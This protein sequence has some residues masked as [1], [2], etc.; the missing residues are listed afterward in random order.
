M[1]D[2]P[3]TLTQSLV[4]KGT[5]ELIYLN[6]KSPILIHCVIIS[7][8]G[9]RALNEGGI[10]SIPQLAFPGGVLVGCSPGFMNV[11]KIKGTHNAM[12]SA[13]VAADSVYDTVMN[14]SENSQTAGR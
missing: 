14:K 4:I 1:E 12:K 2:F 5:T 8:P 10:Q 9:A 7:S 11:A 6:V 3:F 13:L